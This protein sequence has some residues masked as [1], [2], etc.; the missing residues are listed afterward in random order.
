M[1]VPIPMEPFRPRQTFH[2]KAHSPSS[3]LNFPIGL[4]LRVFIA[5]QEISPNA[6]PL[7]FGLEAQPLRRRNTTSHL[8]SAHSSIHIQ[9]YQH[10]TWLTQLPVD[11]VDLVT[12]AVEIEAGEIEVAAVAVVVVEVRNQR[13]RN[14]NQSPSWA[15]S[16][17]L[18]RS[19]AWSRSTCTHCPSRSTKSSIGS[20]PS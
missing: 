8:R 9:R 16:S 19:R 14:G 10:P 3:A 20:C 5:W 1:L 7:H 2:K 4:G 11:V 12:E 15:V 13:R 6:V 17:R 18:A